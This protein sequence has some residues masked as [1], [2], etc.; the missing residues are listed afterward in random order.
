MPSNP[1]PDDSVD[2]RPRG[3]IGK[4]HETRGSDI[5]AI[6]KTLLLPESILG[7]ETVKRLREVKPEQWYP[8]GWLI[9]LMEELDQRVGTYA[10]RRM[11][12]HL[13]QLSHEARTLQVASCAR[14]IVYGID[15]MYHYA[16]RG[17]AIGGRS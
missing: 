9:E 2:R 14:D 15:G 5:L 4:G 6:L 7:E 8:I 11:G 10:L 13:F 1:T 12:R 16:N 3:Y 17:E